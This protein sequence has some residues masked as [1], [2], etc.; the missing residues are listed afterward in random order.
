MQNIIMPRIIDIELYRTI[1]ESTAS[2]RA[3]SLRKVFTSLLIVL[4]IVA[5][6]IAA[7]GYFSTLEQVGAVIEDPTISMQ[8]KLT[9][10]DEVARTLLKWASFLR[11]VIPMNP[12][13][14]VS[15]GEKGFL[16][17]LESQD[18]ADAAV[19]RNT[20]ST[21]AKT[22]ALIDTF[23]E[24]STLYTIFKGRMPRAQGEFQPQPVNKFLMTT[25]MNFVDSLAELNKLKNI[26]RTM[27]ASNEKVKGGTRFRY[28]FT[29]QGTYQ[30]FANFAVKL[31][32]LR[33][34]IAPVSLLIERDDTLSNL[35]VVLGLYDY[36][37]KQ[38]STRVA[39][40]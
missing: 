16:C 10:G 27:V 37:Q 11:A 7:Y 17:V 21:F 29:A 18:L 32:D 14:L 35:E 40:K 2:M 24:N 6:G 4:L 33:Y 12:K 34:A 13:L 15:D 39:S 3:T 19:Q 22:V 30:Q 25:V 28:K 36:T 20:L 9:L 23:T 31:K 38:D 8:D 1:D 5:G 26:S